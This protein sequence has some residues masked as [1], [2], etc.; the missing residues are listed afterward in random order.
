MKFE[1]GDIVTGNCMADKYTITKTGWIGI[2]TEANEFGFNAQTIGGDYNGCKFCNLD[3]D[4]FELLHPARLLAEMLKPDVSAPELP[5]L[6]L[7]KECYKN[8]FKE[9]KP[10]PGLYPETYP[11]HV[12]KNSSDWDEDEENDI[13]KIIFNEPATILFAFGKKYTVKAHKEKFDKEKGLALA[14]LKLYGISYP[15]LKRM[16]KN[17]TDQ[18]ENKK[19]KKEGKKNG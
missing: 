10:I 4:C 13:E 9:C 18:K 14:L 1:V 17:A 12:D 2:V 16:I 5:N 15:D 3:N 8:M 6:A 7:S 11:K 19:K